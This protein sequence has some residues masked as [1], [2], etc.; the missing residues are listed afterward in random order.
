[1]TGISESLEH[2][3]R[4]LTSNLNLA[5]PK[6]SH[7][8]F[9]LEMALTLEHID[10]LRELHEQLKRRIL[11]SDCYV[12]SDLLTLDSYQP[13]QYRYTFKIRDNLKNKLLKLEVERRQ[14]TRSFE[15]QLQTLHDR[16]L[17]VVRKH[18]VVTPK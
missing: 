3:A 17:K 7:P 9:S 11:R 16:L 14:L 15:E 4:E 8:F 18:D 12:G 6:S 1:M 13:R 2:R 5:N 10:K